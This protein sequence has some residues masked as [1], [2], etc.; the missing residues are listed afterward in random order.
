MADADNPHGNHNAFTYAV[1]LNWAPVRFHLVWGK[2]EKG[3]TQK[4]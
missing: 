4:M 3:K 1:R 2:K